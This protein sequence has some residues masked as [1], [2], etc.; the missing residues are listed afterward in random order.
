MNQIEW[1]SFPVPVM[2]DKESDGLDNGCVSCHG[3]SASIAGRSVRTNPYVET[4]PGGN[5]AL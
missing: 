4:S 3:R 2:L 5:W 1:Y